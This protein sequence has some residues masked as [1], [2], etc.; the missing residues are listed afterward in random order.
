[1]GAHTRHPEA[2]GNRVN[3]VTMLTENVAGAWLQLKMYLL[4]RV[5]SVRGVYCSRYKARLLNL[6]KGQSMRFLKLGFIHQTTPLG[7]ISGSLDTILFLAI[8]H[9]TIQI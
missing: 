6:L 9:G 3:V 4:T 2:A 1:M 7:P 5:Y 8:F